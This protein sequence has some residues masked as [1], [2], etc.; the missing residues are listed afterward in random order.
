ME[1]ASERFSFRR[2]QQHQVFIFVLILL[3]AVK[4]FLLLKYLPVATPDTAAYKSYSDLILQRDASLSRIDLRQFYVH[5][6]VIRMIGYPALIAFF[7][8]IAGGW[9]PFA[10]CLFQM[11]LSF[12]AAWSFYHFCIRLGLSSTWAAIAVAAYFG[13]YPVL[14]DQF[15]LT[16][17]VF[18][19][20]L[21][22]FFCRADALLFTDKSSGAGVLMRAGALLALAALIRDTLPLQLIIFAPVFVLAA[23]GPYQKGARSLLL[24]LPVVLTL[25]LYAGWNYWRSGVF[26]LTSAPQSSFLE[27]IFN[28]ASR[29]PEVLEGRDVLVETAR[30]S[31]TTFD[32]SQ[33]WKLNR[34]LY[35]QHG[36]NS[37]EIAKIVR[38][39]YFELWRSHPS[40]ML[41]HLV[42]ELNWEILF[43]PFRTVEAI[44]DLREAVHGYSDWPGIRKLLQRDSST[45][46][47]SELAF[48][49]V[50]NLSRAAGFVVMLF[51]LIGV[52]VRFIAE[53]RTPEGA[54]QLMRKLAAYWVVFIVYILIFAA[55]HIDMR[56]LMPVL[57]LSSATGLLMLRDYLH[58]RAARG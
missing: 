23:A 50:V 14:Q 28:V 57:P 6:T 10:M 7:R 36:F 19:S 52:P 4:I 1:H 27:P 34:E 11:A 5:P 39:K 16:D 29:H 58:M 13:A 30:Q 17:S 2:F 56:Y 53:T 37:L 22:I 8:L 48:L 38:A 55:V 9:W 20:I 46:R 21:L 40:F 42:G 51:F 31:I 26:F 41:E 24:F 45:W 33:I 12:L 25:T 44:R 35:V 3:C 43:S 18:S 49:L 15:L 47:L 32:A 54:S